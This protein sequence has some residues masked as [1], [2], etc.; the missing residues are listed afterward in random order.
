MHTSS[1][2]T[3]CWPQRK[4]QVI[5]IDFKGEHRKRQYVRHRFRMGYKILRAS[6]TVGIAG[7]YS[8]HR[9]KKGETY[10]KTVIIITTDE[11]STLFIK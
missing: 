1:I 9:N 2:Q 4:R 5:P 7:G 11:S 3:Y 8:I 6:N 10:N